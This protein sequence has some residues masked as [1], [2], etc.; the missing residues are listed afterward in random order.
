ME[1][2]Y[3]FLIGACIG[4]F[5]NVLVDRWSADQSIMGRSHCDYCKKTLSFLDLV[6]IFSYVF[7]QG[8]CRYC[9]KKLS[10]YYPIVELITAVLF[11]LSWTFLGI[12]MIEKVSFLG[13]TTCLVVIFFSDLKYQLISERILVGFAI[14]SLPFFIKHPLDHFLSGILL[15]LFLYL[16]YFFSK[17]KGMG[18]GDVELAVVVGLFMGLKLGA[19]ALYLS[20]IIGGGFSLIYL[21]INAIYKKKT[22][23]IMKTK[24]P[25]GPFIIT[26]VFLVVYFER[27]FINIFHKFFGM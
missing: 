11:V 6:P 26:S 9:K 24:I 10:I 19:I 8:K 5:V 23:K 4:S 25:F 17:G 21:A 27:Y 18:F 15:G 7:L 3:I 13:I 2:A 22:K 12:D 16:I 20:F 14:F 1:I